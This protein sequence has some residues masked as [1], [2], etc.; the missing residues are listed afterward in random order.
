MNPLRPE[1]TLSLLRALQQQC[2]IKVETSNSIFHISS[3]IRFCA[4]IIVLCSRLLYIRRLT[5][6]KYGG[7][8][9]SRTPC[10]DLMGESRICYHLRNLQ[11]FGYII[12]CN[13]KFLKCDPRPSDKCEVFTGEVCV[14]TDQMAQMVDVKNAFIIQIFNQLMQFW[15]L[16]NEYVYHLH[17]GYVP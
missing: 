14:D 8:L 13:F 6:Y 3:E 1:D 9:T 17:K 4:W 12:E 11:P 10:T 15:S 2:P 7:L 16:K 5:P